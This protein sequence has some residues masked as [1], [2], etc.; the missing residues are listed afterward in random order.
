MY[1]NLLIEIYNNV[2]E[3]LLTHFQF[4]FLCACIPALV[5]LLAVVQP[6]SAQFCWTEGYTRHVVSHILSYRLTHQTLIF[7]M[8]DE[9]PSNIY[10]PLHLPDSE[11]CTFHIY[12]C[13]IE[14]ILKSSAFKN[15]PF[16]DI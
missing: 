6:A 1:D 4:G 10:T 12:T 5:C 15:R 16:I 11:H 8:L 7:Q 3:M 13:N 14:Q 9:L 2:F